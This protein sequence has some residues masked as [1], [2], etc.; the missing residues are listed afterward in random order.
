MIVCVHVGRLRQILRYRCATGSGCA[1]IT[2]AV[3]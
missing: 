3:V 2:F 1:A